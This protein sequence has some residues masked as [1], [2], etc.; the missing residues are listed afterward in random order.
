M[1]EIERPIASTDYGQWIEVE[2]TQMCGWKP[3]EQEPPQ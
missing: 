2:C 1:A 3:S